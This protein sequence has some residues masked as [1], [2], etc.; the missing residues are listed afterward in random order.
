MIQHVFT[1]S[2][3]IPLLPTTVVRALSTS[4]SR[5]E[6][7]QRTSPRTINAQYA[8]KLG[9]GKRRAA[10]K[11]L[12]KKQRLAARHMKFTNQQL[13]IEVETCQP[14]ENA[15]QQQAWRA[16]YPLADCRAKRLEDLT[17]KPQPQP[18]THTHESPL[19]C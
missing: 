5:Q 19:L 4:P 12:A 6:R 9:T 17:T 3:E 14:V 8:H 11:H 7:R 10:Q 13:L 15:A 2:H 18:H 1:V 16:A